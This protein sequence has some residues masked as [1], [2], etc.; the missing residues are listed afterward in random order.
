MSKFG[1]YLMTKS[2]WFVITFVVAVFFNF[3]LPRLMPGNPVDTMMARMSAGGAAG[4]AQVKMYQEY[5]KEFGLNDPIWQQFFDYV[6]NLLHGDM[7]KSFA[8]YPTPVTTLIGQALPWT[9]V[10][11]VPAILIG[12]IVGN[13]LG[14]MVAYRKGLLDKFVFPASLFIST[15]PFFCLAIL[16]LYLFAVVW[17]VFPPVGGYSFAM[18][19]TFTLDF[20]FS[21]AQHYVLPFLSLVL[22]FIGGQAIGMRSMSIYELD[23]DYVRYSRSLGVSDNRITRYIFRNAMLPQ[24]TGLALS[25][26]AVVSGALIVELVFSYPGIGTQL[27]SSIRQED[28]PVIQGIT[29]IITIAVLVA[30]FSVDIIYGFIDP[31]IR[32]AQT[33]DR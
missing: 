32:A 30:N 11:Q 12:W 1:R 23:A 17:H 13:V 21:A 27:F 6:G 29:L 25:L 7:G 19:P 24:V 15:M 14:V 5:V 18:S 22:V 8:Q 3:M 28:Y 10:L 9:I 33:G 31:R 20:F 4:P 26:A 2:M 16:L